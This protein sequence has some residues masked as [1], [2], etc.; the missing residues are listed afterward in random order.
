MHVDPFQETIEA[1]RLA[2]E[3]LFVIAPHK[4]MRRR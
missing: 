4:D 3:V 2:N 1:K